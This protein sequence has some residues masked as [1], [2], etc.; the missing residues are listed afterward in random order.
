MKNQTAALYRVENH[1]LKAN[2]QYSLK[3]CQFFINEL[4]KAYK[5]RESITATDG[6]GGVMARA[7]FKNEKRVIQLPRWARNPYVIIHEFAHHISQ[8]RTGIFDHEEVFAMNLLRLTRLELD[9]YTYKILKSQYK[10]QNIKKVI[11]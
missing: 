10:V 7:R 11:R 1:I 8:K 9:S 3:E 5:M 4:R 6:R 2:E